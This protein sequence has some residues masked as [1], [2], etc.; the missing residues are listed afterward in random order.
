MSHMY[1]QSL[2][3]YSREALAK[4][5]ESE[6]VEIEG[7]LFRHYY[8]VGSTIGHGPKATHHSKLAL[9]ETVRDLIREGR[10]RIGQVG[11]EIGMS[12][13]WFQDIKW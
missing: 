6:R 13:D 8:V 3:G 11:L 10:T 9:V 12:I 5:P 1:L 7:H 4:I 2:E